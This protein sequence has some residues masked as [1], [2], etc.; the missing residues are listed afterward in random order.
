MGDCTILHSHCGAVQVG[1]CDPAPPLLHRRHSHNCVGSP[2]RFAGVSREA[3]GATTFRVTVDTSEGY[4]VRGVAVRPGSAAR[5]RETLAASPRWDVMP[6]WALHT[7][8]STR[9]QLALEPGVSAPRT[10]SVSM[11]RAIRTRT[12][13]G[14]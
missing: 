1:G 9:V 10:A 6:D 12:T 3:G 2:T 7:A 8:G 14:R 5:F 11:E 4:G 13:E